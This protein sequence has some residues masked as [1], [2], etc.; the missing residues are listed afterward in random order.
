MNSPSTAL[1]PRLWN[2]WLL[3]STLAAAAAMLLLLC[4]IVNPV[5]LTA[6]FLTMWAAAVGYFRPF[7]GFLCY[8]FSIQVIDYL[9]RLLLVFGNPSQVE[10]YGILLLPDVILLAVVLGTLVA[11]ENRKVFHL[12]KYRAV[13]WALGL[14]A[15]WFSV[16]TL[17]TDAPLLNAVGKW[18][19]VVPYFVCFYLGERLITNLAAL[20]SVLKLLAI[21]VGLAALYGVWQLFFGL[22]GFEERWLYGGYTSLTLGTMLYGDGLTRVF[23]FYSDPATFC[24]LLACVMPLLLFSRRLFNAHWW[25]SWLLIG[26]LGAGMIATVIRSGWL[27]A[28]LG[29][30]MWWLQSDVRRS[31]KIVLLIVAVVGLTGAVLWTVSSVTAVDNQLLARALVTG[32]YSDRAKGFANLLDKGIGG[33]IVGRGTASLSSSVRDI[34]G[35]GFGSGPNLDS[36]EDV[37]AH[38]YITE[39]LYELGWIGLGLIVFAVSRSLVGAPPAFLGRFGPAMQFLVF[40]VPLIAALF[41]GSAMEV[42]PVITL[43]WT[44]AGVLCSSGPNQIA[45]RV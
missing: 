9:K 3:P 8:L 14:Y 6:F 37:I 36:P 32:T 2:Q 30:G 45:S 27:L 23:S 19:L 24:Q 39:T 4:Q 43:V 33:F 20:R 1:A 40:G 5:F 28:S 12:R 21:T 11:S 35:S 44:A 16:R 38:D 34:S 7:P 10:W 15:F 13:A 26:V 25:N 42:R 41:G 18:K 22:T 29:V 17:W 31:R